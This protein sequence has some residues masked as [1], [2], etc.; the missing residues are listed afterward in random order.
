MEEIK[1][2]E[3]VEN[4]DKINVPPGRWIKETISKEEVENSDKINVPPG[5]WIK[6]T[7]SKEEVENSDKSNSK[8]FDQNSFTFGRRTILCTIGFFNKPNLFLIGGM[9]E[10]IFFVVG[11]ALIVY[12]LSNL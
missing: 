7:I 6:E 1:S 12:F 8:I 2:I 3:E 9:L 11:C 5:R 4:S 10:L